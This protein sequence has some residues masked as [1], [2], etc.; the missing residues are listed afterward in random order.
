LKPH[1]LNSTIRVRFP[2]SY[3]V[4]AGIVVGNIGN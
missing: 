1:S 2:Y 4:Y 3:D